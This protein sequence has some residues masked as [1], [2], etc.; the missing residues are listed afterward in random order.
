MAKSKIDWKEMGM[1]VLVAGIGAALAITAINYVP[2][3]Y[4]KVKTAMMPKP[5][6]TAP[7]DTTPA[8]G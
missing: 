7:I 5:T 8:N 4:G 3:M 2:K 6:D 1:G